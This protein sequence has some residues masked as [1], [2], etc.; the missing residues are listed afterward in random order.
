[1]FSC[2]D[3]LTCKRV[4]VPVPENILEVGDVVKQEVTFDLSKLPE[5]EQRA[6]VR[7]KKVESVCKFPVQE[8]CVLLLHR[9]VLKL[10]NFVLK[11][12]PHAHIHIQYV[13]SRVPM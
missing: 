11:N 2:E 4:Q 3:T 10:L 6:I 1:M 7:R 13:A 12:T 5:A 9:S 8:V